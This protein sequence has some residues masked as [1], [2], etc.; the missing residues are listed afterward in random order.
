MRATR[1]HA[2]GGPDGLKADDLPD[3]VAGPGEVLVRVRATSLNYRDLMMVRGHYNPKLPL[4]AVP[5]SDGAG[6]VAAVGPGAAKFRVGDR[7]A[8]AFMPGWVDGAP[9]D[10]NAR[11]A[12]GAGGVGML[13]ELVALP[14]TGLVAVPEHLTFEEAATLPCA[15]VTAWHALVT[16]GQIKAGDAVLVQGT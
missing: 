6:E 12:L 2:L 15:A 10:A 11:S 5:L 9:N 16:E 7:V 1:I 4:P 8:A 13:A 14:E 3:P